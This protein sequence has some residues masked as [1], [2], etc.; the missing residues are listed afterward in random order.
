MGKGQTS[1]LTSNPNSVSTHGVSNRVRRFYW[2]KRSMKKTS[3]AL[4]RIPRS[5]NPLVPVRQLTK[6][7][8]TDRAIPAIQRA[9][10][11]CH[12]E[13]TEVMEI[14][15][16]INGRPLGD[17]VLILPLPKDTRQGR[18]HLPDN[19]QE[20]QCVGI[21]VGV[22]KG[23]IDAGRRIAL[24]VSPHNYVQFSKY[25]S[26]KVQ[27]FNKEGKMYEL[28]QIHEQEISFAVGGHKEEQDG[29]QAKI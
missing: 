14:L 17:K 28:F 23:H 1:K 26:Q 13:A 16:E 22:G 29:D 8:L 11:L 5:S 6:A 24:D 10:V 12:P 25:V 21:V 15:H 2:S 20:D 18:I 7:D 3:T 9:Q 4:A 27:V 19:A